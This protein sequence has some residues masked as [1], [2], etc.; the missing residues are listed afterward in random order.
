MSKLEQVKKLRELTGAGISECLNALEK[1]EFNF[2]KANQYLRENI[3]PSNKPIGAGAI[4]SYIHHNQKIGVL[5][6]LQ[7]GTDF[8]SQNEGFK[9]LGKAIAQHIAA[10]NPSS[11]EDL[12]S[13]NYIKNESYLI[14]EMID[15]FSS[16][17]NEPIKIHRFVRYQLGDFNVQNVS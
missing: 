16:R 10:I 11:I 13:Q 9:E 15:T 6:E 2:D 4:F 1:S 5:L 12:L 8:V 17:V 14:S 3:R 7:C